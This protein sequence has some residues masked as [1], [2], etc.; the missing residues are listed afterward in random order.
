LWAKE[1]SIAT[2]TSSQRHFALVLAQLKEISTILKE[3]QNSH[4]VATYIDASKH[5]RLFL[6]SSK[7]NISYTMKAG[8]KSPYQ[9][10]LRDKKSIKMLNNVAS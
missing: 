10:T 5:P 4:V 9:T 1:I 2:L 7:F 6:S 3:I 8:S